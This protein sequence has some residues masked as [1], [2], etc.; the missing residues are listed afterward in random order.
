MPRTLQINN[1]CIS[2]ESDCFVIA[3]IGHNHMGDLDV[4]KSMFR[5]AK[6][7]GVD[8]VKLQKR[9]NRS[10][11]TEAM[12][13]SPYENENSYGPTYG[14]HREALEFG[15]DQYRALKQYA[16]E[17]GVIFFA[18]AFDIPSA[19]FLAELDM[20]AYK[21]ASGDLTNIPLIRHL[22]TF[23]RPLIL[24]TGGA[25]MDDVHRAYECLVAVGAQFSFLQCTATYPSEPEDM[26]LAVIP[27]YRELFPDTV[28]GLSDH[29]NGIALTMVAYTLGARIVE[30][31]FTLNRAWK[32]TD[33]AFS[34]EPGGL[35]RLVRDLKRAR[36]AMGSSAKRR[37]PKEVAP[38]Q[39]M[40]KQIV[41]LRN[42][43]AGHVL[44]ASDVTLKSPGGGLLPYQLESI[45]GRRLVHPVAV[46]EAIR[47]E[48]LETPS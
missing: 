46:D 36:V 44:S 15:V 39:K 34:L 45:L 14:L 19:N 16:S 10:L 43:S 27:T 31:H 5:V 30:K 1:T 4:A 25:T 28:I 6:E 33:H 23:N 12:F 11:F 17:L 3:E 32:G 8:A 26:D 13:N 48:H 37:F 38:I 7:C 2:D 20:P 29:H 9:D 40:A 42:L 35:R 21:V 24:S 22:A 41:A 47:F 18:T